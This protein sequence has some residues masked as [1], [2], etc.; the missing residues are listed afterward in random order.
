MIARRGR[1]RPGFTLYESMAALGVL[2]TAAI[3]A[4]QIATY[5][6]IERGRTLER[7]AATDAAANVLEAARARP[8]AD[9]TAEW[10]AAQK[11]PEYLHQRLPDAALT[12]YMT[13]E[14]EQSHVKRVTVEVRW[15]IQP[16]IPAKTVTLVGLM[17]ERS[18]G[19]GS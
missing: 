5:S 15:D 13:E 12:V 8:W 14:A 17:A 11:L 1:S 10:A 7:L 9:L 3:L 6:M 19:G 2:A 18:A 4:A 16:S